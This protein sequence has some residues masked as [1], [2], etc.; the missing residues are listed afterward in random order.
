MLK[1]RFCGVQDRL[2]ISESSFFSA[3]EPILIGMQENQLK[4]AKAAQPGPS[5]KAALK[6]VEVYTDGGCQPNPGPGGWG[7]VLICNG[8]E[9]ELYGFEAETTN[10]RMEML[11]AIR[12]LEALKFPCRVKLHSDSA[13][14]INAF[15]K[16]WIPGWQRKGWVNASKEPVKNRDLWERLMELSRDH[17]MEWVKVKGHSGV[18]YNERC[19]QLCNQ[20]IAEGRKR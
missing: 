1:F 9:K 10:N 6:L 7:A 18:H 15:T 20:A 13:L 11:A 14:L 8:R 17:Q 3:W 19:D 12:A 2:D 4:L 5:S 16:N